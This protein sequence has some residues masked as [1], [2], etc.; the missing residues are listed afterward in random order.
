M[1]SVVPER[2]ELA[3]V[4]R[5]EAGR[6]YRPPGGFDG[7]FR[8]RGPMIDYLNIIAGTGNKKIPWEHVSVS[9][10]T[11]CPVWEEMSFVKDLFW[12]DEEC[13]IQYHPPKS[14]YVNIHPNVLHLWKPIGVTI[15]LPPRVAV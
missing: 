15:P 12:T 9:A 11:R 6:W 13:V 1:R 14:E 3:R 5:H 7:C 8:L 4:S 10:A 2:L